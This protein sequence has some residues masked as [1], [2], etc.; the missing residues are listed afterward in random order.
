M[1]SKKDSRINA[2]SMN[3]R[4]Y[5]VLFLGIMGVSACHLFI[6]MSQPHIDH[7]GIYLVLSMGMYLVVISFLMM[8]LFSVYRRH[9]LM[10]PIK[11]LGDAARM[12]AQGDFSVRIAPQ[13]Q[14]GKKDE[15]EVLYEDFNSMTEELASTEMLKKDFVS[16]VSHELKTPI[17]VIQ[18]YATILQSGS[19]TEEEKKE[20]IDKIGNAS[21][22]LA[23]LIT[24]ILQISRL[25]NQ[26]VAVNRSSYNLSEQL[27]R[28]ALGF[29]QIWEDKNIELETNLDQE[30]VLFN[31]ESLLDIVW[32]NLLGNALK[33]TEPGG[34]VSIEARKEE[35]AAIVRITDTGCGIDLQAQKH[36]FDKFYQEDTSHA[37]KGNGLG[38]AMVKEIV[39]LVG[40]EIYV[41]SE[42]GKGSC[43]TVKIFN[44]AL[45]LH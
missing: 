13:R 22:Q 5:L 12:V 20:Y 3:W 44:T 36:I 16:N 6:Y 23:G 25:E 42:Q 29:E 21:V 38:L 32:N 15:F 9:L 19:L 14:D 35:T 7:Q 33:F 28:C 2:S 27:C 4:Q 37:T 26:K 30:I 24:N 17:A 45:T 43:F 10:K 40:G 41:G 1:N 39:D 8:I 11:M 34:K 18:N 31:D